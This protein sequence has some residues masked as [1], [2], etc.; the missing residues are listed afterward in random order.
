M[1]NTYAKYIEQADKYIT[2]GEKEF[3]KGDLAQASEKFWGGAVQILKAYC[4]LKGWPHNG[5]ALL[6][7][8]VSNLSVELGNRRIMEQFSLASTLHTNF[9]EGWLT[10][11]QVEDHIEQT[12]KFISKMKELIEK[13]E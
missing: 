2:Q 3:E 13:N 12:K 1:K 11:E 10:R 6:F 8:N 5:H 9:Y 7:K 4:E